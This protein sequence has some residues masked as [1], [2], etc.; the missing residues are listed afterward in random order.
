MPVAVD[1]AAGVVVARGRVLPAGDQVGVG[2]GSPRA[3]AVVA[4]AEEGGYVPGPDRDGGAQPVND[5][6]VAVSATT[7][8]WI[9]LCMSVHLISTLDQLLA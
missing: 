5:I 1:R 9:R 6:A 2:D 3:D 7:T 8:T 4:P